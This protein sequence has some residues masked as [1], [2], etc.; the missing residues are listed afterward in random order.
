MK[1]KK[2]IK[3]RWVIITVLVITAIVGMLIPLRKRIIKHNIIQGEEAIIEANSQQFHQA[4][5]EKSGEYEIFPLADMIPVTWDKA[6]LFGSYYSEKQ[7]LEAV[8]Y[9]WVTGKIG[10]TGYIGTYRLVFMKDGL[11]VYDIQGPDSER[12]YMHFDRQ[13]ITIEENPMVLTYSDDKGVETYILPK[14]MMENLSAGET[15]S[16]EEKAGKWI[17]EENKELPLI[18]TKEGIL[19]F[20]FHHKYFSILWGRYA[21]N[22]RTPFISQKYIGTSLVSIKSPFV[23][24]LEEGEDQLTLVLTYEQEGKEEEAR[25]S[26]RKNQ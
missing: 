4:L 20:T 26:Y 8:G 9:R 12:V 23:T 18:I 5:K 6:Y 19:F 16:L 2:A 10:E 14:K 15:L 7:V 3:W 25:L 11:V 22:E 17:G 13:E 24:L 21:P 1:D